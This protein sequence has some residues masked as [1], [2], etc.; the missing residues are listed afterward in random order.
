LR[1]APEVN[2]FHTLFCYL[3]PEQ[4]CLRTGWSH[5]MEP[6]IWQIRWKLIKR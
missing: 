4:Y 2:V 3:P 6:Q 1:R 5:S